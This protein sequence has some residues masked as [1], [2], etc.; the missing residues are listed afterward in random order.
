[1]RLA[2]SA[3]WQGKQGSLYVFLVSCLMG[4]YPREAFNFLISLHSVDRDGRGDV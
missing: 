2:V 1:M 4:F 3:G